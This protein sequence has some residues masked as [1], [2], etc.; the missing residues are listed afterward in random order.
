[1]GPSSLSSWVRLIASTLDSCGVDADEVFR[2]AKM[3][4]TQLREPNSR[5]PA[6]GLQRLWLLA[7]EAT[8]DP[9]FGMEVGRS[10]HP[11]S[12]HALGYAALA[13]STLRQALEY[14][15]RYSRV[16]SSGA[17][18]ALTGQGDEVEL[19]LE[20]HLDAPGPAAEALRAPA[21]AG[22][23]AIV[24]LCREARGAPIELRRVTFAHQGHAGAARLERFF[25][26]PIV[27]GANHSALVFPAAAVDAALGTANPV[28][29]GVNEQ[30][31]ARYHAHLESSELADRVR[32]Q[33]LR[34]LPSGDVRQSS[35]AR[36]LHLSL[37]SMQRKLADE[38]TSFRALLDET[39]R[40]L[41]EQYAKD[42]TLSAAEVAYLLG[43]S[44]AR[45][46]SRARQRW[47]RVPR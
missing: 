8:G 20:S 22:L 16:V 5:Y 26:C 27:F 38:G 44:E 34:S 45:S 10:W 3:P 4:A 21:Q 42:E 33:L 6:S 9:C 24:V 19:R 12:F 35:I 17:R 29:L 41:A 7:G 11:T 2:R 15:V 18:L 32:S 46:F 39:R 25:G 47:I 30:V 13:S 40:R 28:L 36:S 31:L 14:I 23:A 1:M 43:F 37:R